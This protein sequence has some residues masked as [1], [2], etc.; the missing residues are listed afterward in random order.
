MVLWWIIAVLK[1]SFADAV[2]FA[3]LAKLQVGKSDLLR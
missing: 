2:V 1:R 3:G